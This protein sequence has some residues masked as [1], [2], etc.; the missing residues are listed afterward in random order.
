MLYLFP[1]LN[2]KAIKKKKMKTG[3]VINIVSNNSKSE[4]S[5]GMSLLDLMLRIV[6]AVG[7]LISAIIMVTANQTL[8]FSTQLNISRL[9]F[10]DFPTF[11][12]FVI[13]NSIACAYLVLSLLLSIIH[14]THAAAKNTKIILVVFDTIMLSVVSGGASSAAAIVHL[15]REGNGKA[16]WVAFCQ[17]YNSFCG[18]ISGSL[19]GSFASVI[20]LMLIIIISSLPISP[21]QD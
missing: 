8:P 7:T 2:H 10:H 11:T 3:Q 6:A 19:I 17:Q 9:N 20:I 5:L 18:R 12:F 1:T 14:I 13:A 16:N 21:P 4:L 15:A